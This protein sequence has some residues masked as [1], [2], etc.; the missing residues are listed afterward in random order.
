MRFFF[1]FVLTGEPIFLIKGGKK[2]LTKKKPS[3]CSQ[4]EPELKAL[5]VDYA[6]KEF[7][8]N[9]SLAVRK[10]IEKFFEANKKQKNKSN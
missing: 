8:G 4:I 2:M 1:R 7:G 9:E 5:V 6:K 3:I 10:I